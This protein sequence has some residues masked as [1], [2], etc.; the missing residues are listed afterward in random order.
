MYW[1]LLQGAMD[2]KNSVSKKLE[3]KTGY[4]EVI[5]GEYITNQ[6]IAIALVLVTTVCCDILVNG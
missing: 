4:P 5:P 2:P 6:N 3:R 1:N